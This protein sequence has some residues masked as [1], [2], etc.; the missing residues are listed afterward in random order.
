MQIQIW[1]TDM[2]KSE[3]IEN[4]FACP[5]CG[6]HMYISDDKKSAYCKGVRRHCYDFSSDGYLSFGL[7][8]GDSREAVRARSEFLRKDHYLNAA[9]TLVSV[10]KDILPDSA[11]VIDAGCGE[12]YY[13]SKIASVCDG[14]VGFDLSK[15]AC[16]A[17]SKVSCRGQ[18]NVLFATA[19][20]FKLPVLSESVDA[21]VNIFAPCTEQEYSRV[22]NDGGYIVVAGAGKEHL[23][24]LKKLIYDDPYE[25]VG[26]ADLPQGMTHI[27]KLSCTYDIEV[28][29]NADIMALFS[30]TPYYWRTSCEDKL[31]LCGVERL[32]TTVDF[33]INIYRK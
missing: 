4:I 18:D 32:E 9:N 3:L 1:G 6:A 33:E 20:V 11:R 27:D 17:A 22:L 28:N 2:N 26:R 13:T 31:K 25:N 19:S 14:A 21:V 23:M 29:T 24:G 10:L 7:S 8:G 16:S 12:G 5:C 15:F 30:M